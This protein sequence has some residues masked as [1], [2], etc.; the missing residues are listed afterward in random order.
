[1]NAAYRKKRIGVLMGGMSSE[2]EV[3]RKTGMAILGAL[4]RK[5]YTAKAIDVDRNIA[6]TLLEQAVEVA[7]IA[8]HGPLGEDGTMQGLLEILGIPYTGPG[9][10]ASALA[11]NKVVSKELFLY[12]DLPTPVFQTIVKTVH[13]QATENS[14][15][16]MPLPW[17]IKPCD[18][19]STIGISIVHN[20]EDLPAS[21][22]KAFC[23]SHQ[24]LIE[25]FMQGRELTAGVLNG[26]PL[27]LVEI[28][29]KNG[30]YDYEAKYTAGATDYIVSPD[31]PAATTD[32]VKSIA[33]QAYNTLGCRGGCRVD[34]ILSAENEPFILEVNTI[35]G[36]TETSLLPKAAGAAGIDF[37]TLVEKILWAA[38]LEKSAATTISS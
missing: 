19:G 5:G 1:M 31:L 35:P 22:E 30:F 24:V 17:V 8:L 20:Q 18:Q 26:Q 33:V 11:M 7:F 25:Q 32:R 16:A 13:G 38:S 28:C 21:L 4:Q 2:R 15:I 10:L 6:E 34:V 36:M 9:V 14:R 29:P 12:H 3:S 27:P 37:E 23:H